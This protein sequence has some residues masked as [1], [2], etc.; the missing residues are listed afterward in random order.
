MKL[1]LARALAVALIGSAIA[2]AQQTPPGSTTPASY[3]RGP[4]P[5]LPTLVVGGGEVLLEVTVGARGSVTAVRTL[6]STEPYTDLVI[7]AVKSW[8]F[9]PAQEPIDRINRGPGRP[10]ESKILVAAVF[11]PPSLM[12]GATLGE[13][14]KGIEAPSGETP[15]PLSTST[16]SYP[17]NAR[18][19]GVVLTEVTVNGAGV[20][21]EASVRHSASPFDDA[22][23]AA[24]RLW[25]FQPARGA[26]VARAYLLFGFQVPIGAVNVSPR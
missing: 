5:A 3:L 17:P 12:L 14:A 20:V 4:M 23:L 10:I 18:D 9:A 26:A 16:P 21:T 19:G 25:R 7:S 6:R 8:E 1:G 22:A 24:S 2:V 13:P 15:V 11:R